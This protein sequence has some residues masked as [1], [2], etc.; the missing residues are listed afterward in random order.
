MVEVIWVELGWGLFGCQY[1][2]QAVDKVKILVIEK[3]QVIVKVSLKVFFKCQVQ[4]QGNLKGQ[5]QWKGYCY[6]KM[7]LSFNFAVKVKIQMQLKVKIKKVYS[8]VKIEVM[9]WNT[10]EKN[11]TFLTNL[12]WAKLQQKVTDS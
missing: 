4:G 11:W 10:L 8:Q 9:I 3:L 12:I 1:Q 6:E 7:D 2:C 5:C